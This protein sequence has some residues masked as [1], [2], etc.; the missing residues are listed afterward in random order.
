MTA[1]KDYEEK[2]RGAIETAVKNGCKKPKITLTGHSLGGAIAHL[3][4]N[5][6][7]LSKPSAVEADDIDLV[8][9]GSPRTSNH[10]AAPDPVKN[11]VHYYK[12][13]DI[14]TNLPSN[15]PY[16]ELT[17][18]NFE[19]PKQENY[20]QWEDQNG[21]PLIKN[22]LPKYYLENMD[23]Y[24]AGKLIPTLKEG[25]DHGLIDSVWESAIHGGR[26]ALDEVVSFLPDQT[27]S[28]A[29]LPTGSQTVAG[30]LT[31]N[32]SKP[33]PGRG[34][35]CVA[36]I[37]CKRDSLVFSECNIKANAAAY[38]IQT[39]QDWVKKFWS[40][41]AQKNTIDGLCKQGCDPTYGLWIDNKSSVRVLWEAN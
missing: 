37:T 3:M 14:V 35:K 4:A 12:R 32:P 27:A 10:R 40:N 23:S 18:N 16:I 11:A 28:G 20:L 13:A 5:V 41:D 25:I 2:V 34:G 21:A 9:F 38:N 39:C 36:S 26:A 7:L 6:I 8:L 30:L 33:L 17:K 31:P 1:A 19:F 24:C 15:P 29:K 22:H